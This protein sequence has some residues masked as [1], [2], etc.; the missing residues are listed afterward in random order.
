M[1]L[2]G[3]ARFHGASEKLRW[4]RC[5]R[6]RTTEW[7]MPKSGGVGL[8]RLDGGGSVSRWSK[9]ATALVFNGSAQRWRGVAGA[10]GR[11]GV[12]WRLAFGAGS[13]GFWV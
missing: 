9:R 11:G 8:S 7:I 6:R 10:V 1:A 4:W 13:E 2:L 5:R 3:H 12:G